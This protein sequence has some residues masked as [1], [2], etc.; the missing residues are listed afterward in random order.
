MIALL[1]GAVGGVGLRPVDSALHAFLA[2][3]AATLATEGQDHAEEAHGEGELHLTAEQIEAAG[4]RLADI[5]EG[6]IARQLSAPG[7]ITASA[8]RLARVPA[9][10]AGTVTELHR[11]LGDQVA[12]G[13]V[14]AVVESREMAEAKATYLA[15]VRAEALAR[16]TAERERR[17]WERKISAEQDFLK[18]RTEAEEARIRVDLSRAKL[19]ALGLG[20]A[21]IEALPSQPTDA[22]RRQEIRA[23]LAGRVTDR[24]IDIGTSVSPET[25]A[26]VVADLSVL[27]VELAISASDL[28]HLR[29]GQ[30]VHLTGGATGQAGEGKVVFVSPML[31]SQTRTAR[32]VAELP[33]PDGRWRPGAFVTAGI[34]TEAQSVALSV[35][36]EALQ[37]VEGRTV[38]FVRTEGGFIKRE[39]VL[40]R[41]DERSAEL[42]SGAQ[43]G[44]QVAT[45]NSFVLKAELGKGEAEHAH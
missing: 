40:G 35:P 4:I 37:T 15:A 17:L 14:L 25:E 2:M 9:R 30:A 19:S 29:E 31:D 18:A 33:N 41:R 43:A 22:L 44:E 12:A 13:E 32:A 26:F 20:T 16:T 27:W 21:E 1:I 38:V 39:V 5:G 24:R 36:T 3:P 8:D 7:T 28:A 45:A 10:V 11:R 34:A 42:V 23:P 6:R